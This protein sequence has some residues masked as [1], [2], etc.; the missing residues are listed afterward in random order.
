M[1]GKQTEREQSE[2]RGV[3]DSWRRGNEHATLTQ[4]NHDGAVQ[5]TNRNMGEVG[6]AG[7]YTVPGNEK[8]E[9]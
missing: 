6:H 7:R 2:T 1:T 4:E 8:L 5:Y 3:G 9:L